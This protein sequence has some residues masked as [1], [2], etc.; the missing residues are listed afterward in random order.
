MSRTV[1]TNENP[2]EIKYN[3]KILLY[4]IKGESGRT[5]II[6][7]G[8]NP[9]KCEVPSLYPNAYL[10]DPIEKKDKN[11]I[12]EFIT[13]KSFYGMGEWIIEFK[14]FRE[15]SLEERVAA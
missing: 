5:K 6:V 1:Y 7:Y 9:K 3:N 10:V 11:K 8:E 15:N 14:N 13:K 2:S 4:E 12:R